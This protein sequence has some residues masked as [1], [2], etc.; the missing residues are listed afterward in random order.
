M[1][2]TITV[3]AAQ[4]N[5]K[6]VL[7][8]VHPEHPNGEIF[9][10]GDG[11]SV[12]VALTPAIQQRLNDRRLVRVEVAEP[13]PPDESVGLVEPL[14]GYDAMTAAAVVEL[15]ST[16]TDEQRSAVLA[17]ETAHKNRATVLKALQ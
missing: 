11:Q 14:P 15:V 8:E 10:S 4:V 9:I 12:E 7:W 2:N 17:Y 3:M 6:V 1:A 13:D 16:L 5:G